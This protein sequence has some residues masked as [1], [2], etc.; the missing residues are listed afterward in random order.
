MAST[1]LPHF[2][3]PSMSHQPHLAKSP[4]S[5]LLRI[6]IVSDASNMAGEGKPVSV[7]GFPRSLPNHANAH[8]PFAP[9]PPPMQCHDHPPTLTVP[10]WQQLEQMNLNE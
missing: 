9:V 1:R 8:Q 3:A 6:G 4:Q 5:G 2:L 10:T 7:T